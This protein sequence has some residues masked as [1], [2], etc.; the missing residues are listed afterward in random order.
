MPFASL[1][2][3]A[4]AGGWGS[5]CGRPPGAKTKTKEVEQMQPGKQKQT[6]C[7]SVRLT[8]N[9]LKEIDEARGKTPRGTWCRKIILGA[10]TYNIPEV[11]RRTYI[12]SARWAGALTQLAKEKNLGRI[13]DEV[14]VREV[15][16][17]F[18]LALL[19]AGGEDNES[20]DN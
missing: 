3:L 12:E 13:V 19:G 5:P 6:H 8:D 11:N 18:R 20:E 2:H 15:L 9:E 16:K 14:Q 17:G 4:P 10:N 1:R 7:V